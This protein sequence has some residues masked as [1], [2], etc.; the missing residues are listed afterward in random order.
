MVAASLRA[1]VAH[2]RSRSNGTST[3]DFGAFKLTQFCHQ[4]VNAT[5]FSTIARHFTM[6][7]TAFVSSKEAALPKGR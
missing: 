3:P 7:N 4:G 1:G 6:V 5:R 2:F